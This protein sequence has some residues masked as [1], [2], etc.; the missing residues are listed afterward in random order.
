V[1]NVT[2]EEMHE[3]QIEIQDKLKNLK[4]RRTKLDRQIRSLECAVTLLKQ[5]QKAVVRR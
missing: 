2:R 1:N 4:D 3:A 5:E